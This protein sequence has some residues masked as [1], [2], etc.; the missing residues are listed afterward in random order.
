MHC[1]A[2][3]IAGYLWERE[4]TRR[5]R[6]ITFMGV[7]VGWWKGE[8][9]VDCTAEILSKTRKRPIIIDNNNG[10]FVTVGVV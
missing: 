10:V 4:K 1:C 3:I 7:G 9:A 6:I 2:Q 8:A 5:K